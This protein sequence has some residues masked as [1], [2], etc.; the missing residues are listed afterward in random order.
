MRSIP[1]VSKIIYTIKQVI[2]RRMDG[3]EDFNRDWG[4]YKNGFGEITREYWA[5][6][7]GQI[8]M[9][10]TKK[11]LNKQTKNVPFTFNILNSEYV[12]VMKTFIRKL[13][14]DGTIL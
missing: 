3:S 2:L 9:K 10:C 8:L 11:E 5:G 12:Q 13:T 4:D 6:Q 14:M 7:S 1:G